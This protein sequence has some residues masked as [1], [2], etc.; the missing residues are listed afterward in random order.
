MNRAIL[1][2]C[3]HCQVAEHNMQPLCRTARIT[4]E[5]A[6]II[7]HGAHTIMQD[8]RHR[9]CEEAQALNYHQKHFIQFINRGN[10]HARMFAARAARGIRCCLTEE[11][12]FTLDSL[13]CQRWV[14]GPIRKIR[15]DTVATIAVG[16]SAW[17]RTIRE[18]KL[19]WLTKPNVGLY[20]MVADV[21]SGKILLDD[22]WISEYIAEDDLDKIYITQ[23]IEKRL[24]KKALNTETCIYTINQ[25]NNQ[26]NVHKQNLVHYWVTSDFEDGEVNPVLF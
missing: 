10:R 2:E 4:D 7:L 24:Q 1:L 11:L 6:H 3:D 19:V 20:R 12:A 9:Y 5:I 21:V 13:Y 15:R 22:R 23:D 25:E 26:I 17:A 8:H 16:W 14:D 18:S